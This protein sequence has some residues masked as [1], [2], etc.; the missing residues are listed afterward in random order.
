VAGGGTGATTLT[1]VLIGNG[2]SAVTGNAVTNHY[3]LV[4]GA[5]NAITSV[6]PS[7]SGFIMTS[8]GVSADP[9]FVR[10]PAGS[11]WLSSTQA[12]GG[13]YI[14]TLPGTYNSY[15]LNFVNLQPNTN[16]DFT[17]MT[18]SDDGG[19]TY[20]ASGQ[21]GLN[22]FVY[23][24]AA[25]TNYNSASVAYISGKV[26][27]SGVGNGATGTIF[28]SVRSAFNYTGSCTYCDTDAANAQSIATFGGEIPVTGIPTTIK[29]TSPTTGQLTFGF[30]YLYGMSQ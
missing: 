7:T 21:S 14:I 24:A 30:V 5:S 16:G 12:S 29:I 26:H 3:A 15:L 1:G 23:N 18:V 19:A 4:G 2:T 13:D 11:I 20:Y 28:I 8:N 25:I 22:A 9:S 10:N 17:Q 27:S 6:S